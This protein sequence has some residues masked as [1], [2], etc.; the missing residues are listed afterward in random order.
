MNRRQVKMNKLK[1]LMLGGI[2]L[3][4]ALPSLASNGNPR[5]PS[6]TPGSGA[7]L[8][9]CGARP[10][11]DDTATSGSLNLLAT[12]ANYF[13]DAAAYPTYTKYGVTST[14]VQTG[15][16]AL[17]LKNGTTKYAVVGFTLGSPVGPADEKIDSITWYKVGKP[18]APSNVSISAGYETAKISW[19]LDANYEYSHVDLTIERDVSGT[20]A[21]VPAD[22]GVTKTVLDAA[23]SYIIGQYVDGRTFNPGDQCRVTLVGK[24]LAKADGSSVYQSDPVI[25][26]FQFKTL[27]GAGGGSA[28]FI[29]KAGINTISVPCDTTKKITVAIGGVA[30]TLDINP[31]TTPAGSKITVGQL[32]KAINQQSGVNNFV[33]VVGFY[34]AVKQ[35]HVGLSNIQY[36]AGGAIDTTKGT[37]NGID[38]S[39]TPAAPYSV[40]GVTGLPVSQGQA[41]QITVS[42]NTSLTI[43]Q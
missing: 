20:W 30:G 11:Q 23:T 39:V 9:F 40:A 4:L 41:L 6:A 27:T 21:T 38:Y 35:Q 19:Q 32:V 8:V 12:P 14:P 16:G 10:Y 2:M 31:P 25:T 37:A 1:I 17:L 42:S 33:T 29:L 43:S 22:G 3:A 15:S 28:T 34:D 13:I 5:I 7:A 18:T 26:T 36:A 24:V